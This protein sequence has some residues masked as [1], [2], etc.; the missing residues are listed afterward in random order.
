MAE[1]G[2]FGAEFFTQVILPFILVFTL[3]YA[4]LEKSK[5]LGEGKHQINSIIALVIGLI[6]IGVPLAR[7]VIT[8][9]VPIIAVLAVIILV[10]MLIFGFVGGT[11][12]EGNLN[13]GLKITIGIITGIVLIIAVLWS[14]GWLETIVSAAK[15][16]ESQG[17]WQSVIFIIIIIAVMAVALSGKS[18]EE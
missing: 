5:I 3:V 13:K 15:Q 17:I 4:I 8:D 2:I 11:G 18:K 9:I 7:G 10:F 1:L 6:L 12:K 16:P 14:T